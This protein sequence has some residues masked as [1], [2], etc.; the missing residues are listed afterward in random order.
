MCHNALLFITN[1][2]TAHFRSS[3]KFEGENNLMIAGRFYKVDRNVRIA[4]FGKAVSGMVRAAEDIL[5]DHIVEG[6]AIVPVGTR[7]TFMSHNLG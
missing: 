5:G 7:Q 2:I 3:L 6:I 4:A 1:V